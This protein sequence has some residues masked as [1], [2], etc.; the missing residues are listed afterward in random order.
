[1]EL[2]L[3]IAKKVTQDA[4]DSGKIPGHLTQRAKRYAGTG[5][6]CSRSLADLSGR[7]DWAERAVQ[8]AV[9]CE[10]WCRSGAEVEQDGSYNDG[11]VRRYHEKC[12]RYGV[13][14]DREQLYLCLIA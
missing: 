12:S 4:I 13:T 8:F 6:P 7:T 11:F 1:M 10:M 14:P 3:N 9:K 5:L 2:V